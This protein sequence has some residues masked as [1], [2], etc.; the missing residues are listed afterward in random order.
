[1]SFTAQL[2]Q[3]FEICSDI[4]FWICQLQLSE[5]YVTRVPLGS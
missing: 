2:A 4:L 5:S 3:S 1:M